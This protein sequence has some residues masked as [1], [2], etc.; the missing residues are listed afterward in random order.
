V[1]F[2]QLEYLV[3]LAREGHFGRAAQSC[4]VSQPSLSEGIRKLE[5]EFKIP[6]IQRGRYSSGLT[7]EGERV[8]AWARQILADRDALQDEVHAMRTGLSGQV[9]IGAVPSAATAVPRL[10]DAL[11]TRHPM[12]TAHVA[13]DLTSSDILSRLR[14]FSLD[15]AVT[16]LDE[17]VREAFRT[18]PLYRERHV[19]LTG[20]GSA[21][22]EGGPVAWADAATLPL[23]LLAPSMR[24]R[25][26][27]DVGFS[28]EQAQ[29]VVRVETDSFAS[30]LAHVATG[31]WSGIVP[32]AWLHAFRLPLGLT[33]VPMV[34]SSAAAE[35]G[36]IA[37]R[38]TPESVIVRALFTVARQVDFTG[39]EIL[40]PGSAEP[41]GLA[42]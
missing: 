1:L 25:R 19:L 4:S 13:G 17:E 5:E 27:I 35:I 11:C 8:A 34:E 33:A 21:L 10:T 22:G 3:A 41:E 7:P 40:P 23:C 29:P 16:Y 38:R 31:R 2:R 9:R 28:A 36:L 12:L 39:L 42:G 24:G 20:A 15:A 32:L 37:C 6:L 14:D 18:V 30:V 26:M